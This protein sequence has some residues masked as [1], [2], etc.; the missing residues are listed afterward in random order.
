MT[1]I[2]NRKK[3]MQIWV[4][5]CPSQAWTAKI[6]TVVPTKLCGSKSFSCIL[7]KHIVFF[8]M[9]RRRNVLREVMTESTYLWAVH[10][11][12]H[13]LTTLYDSDLSLL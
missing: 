1:I 12:V 7:I 13:A 8:L 6:Y 3:S 9:N 4:F 5:N 11:P 2:Q 10:K